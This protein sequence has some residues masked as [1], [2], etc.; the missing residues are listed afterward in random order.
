MSGA[1]TGINHQTASVTPIHTFVKFLG[2]FT[3]QRLN[4]ETAG[5]SLC[6]REARVMHCVI[7]VSR[8]G[9]PQNNLGTGDKWRWPGWRGLDGGDILEVLTVHLLR[10]IGCKMFY[11][12][13]SKKYL[14]F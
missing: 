4:I 1:V 13:L 12:Y 14:F 10:F 5:A 9:W 6:S 8:E 11:L 7:S 3:L 2:I